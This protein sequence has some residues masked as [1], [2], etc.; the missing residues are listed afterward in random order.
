M[1]VMS[2]LIEVRREGKHNYYHLL[3]KKFRELRAI[4]ESQ[5]NKTVI[6]RLFAD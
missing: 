6:E 2:G 5:A 1:L 3:P 4:F